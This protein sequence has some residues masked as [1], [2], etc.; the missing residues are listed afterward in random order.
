[1]YTLVFLLVFSVNVF[2]VKGSKEFERIEAKKFLE[3]ETRRESEAR[4]SDPHTVSL[5]IKQLNIYSENRNQALKIYNDTFTHEKRIQYDCVLSNPTDNEEKYKISYYVDGSPKAKT[6]GNVTLAPHTSE[7]LIYTFTLHK[8][9]RTII[10][11]AV[12]LSSRKEAPNP[13]VEIYLKYISPPPVFPVIKTPNV[14]RGKYFPNNSTQIYYYN[15]TD[16]EQT[17]FECALNDKGDNSIYRIA[18]YTDDHGNR[19]F[20]PEMPVS[21]L[22][23]LKKDNKIITCI[24][25]NS[26]SL[27]K[28]YNIVYLNCNR[29]SPDTPEI[30]IRGS[31]N[32]QKGDFFSANSTQMYNYTICDSETV[33]LSCNAIGKAKTYD[34]IFYSDG[35]EVAKS[36]QVTFIENDFDIT[37]DSRNITCV[38]LNATHHPLITAVVQ[39]LYSPSENYGE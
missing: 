34:L 4:I 17:K 23:N 18:L 22:F 1:M 10:C 20:T 24:V 11:S 33:K 19:T 6:S 35:K 27:Q 7:S 8:A 26:Q 30:T 38:A 21:H 16:G 5:K 12:D 31:K 14:T 2:A 36:E 32:L 39:L 28:F 37:E 3:K 13:R 9:D 25:W 15:F 29:V